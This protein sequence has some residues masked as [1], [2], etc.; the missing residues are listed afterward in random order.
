MNKKNFTIVVLDKNIKAFII[1]FAFFNLRMKLITHQAYKAQ[2]VLFSIKKVLKNILDKYQNLINMFLKRL[3]I[4]LFNCL[5]TNKN[6]I[7]LEIDKKL[8][9]KP[10]Y[11]FKL[12]ELEI[13]K[14]YI[15]IYLANSFIW[16]FKFFIRAFILFVRN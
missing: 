2:I 6:T 13:F 3:T 5:D 4:E 14:N 9:Y 1:P 11:S 10:I 12:V 7:S 15:K 16:I 8:F